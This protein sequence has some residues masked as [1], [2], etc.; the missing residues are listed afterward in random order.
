M[1]YWWEHGLF[2]LVIMNCPTI[3]MGMLVS[4]FIMFLNLSRRYWGESLAQVE[5]PILVF[6]GLSI[7]IPI[8]V[9]L[10]Y[11][12]TNSIEGFLSSTILSESLI[13]IFDDRLS[14]WNKMEPHFAFFWWLICWTP[15]H[16]SFSSWYF[17]TEVSNSLVNF[18]DWIFFGEDWFFQILCLF[19]VLVPWWWMAD[20]L[21]SLSLDCLC[22]ILVVFFAMYTVIWSHLLILGTISWGIEGLSRKSLLLAFPSNILCMLSSTKLYVSILTFRSSIYFDFSLVHGELGGSRLNLL[23]GNN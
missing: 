10:I 5:C 8:V 21:V 16:I 13:W 12:P 3:D 11:I 15:F 22:S 7:L 6:W 1:W 18:S 2:S 19:Q 4:P 23:H 17:F 20:K 14:D 9:V